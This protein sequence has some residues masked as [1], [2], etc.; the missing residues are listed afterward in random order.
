MV[1]GSDALNHIG[2]M[3]L[4]N[5]TSTTSLRV[6]YN[7][8]TDNEPTFKME[9]SNGTLTTTIAYGTYIDPSTTGTL[10]FAGTATIGTATISSVNI[11]N[12][13]ATLTGLVVN[14]TAT[15]SALTVSGTASVSTLIL[16]NPIPE[17]SV[18]GLVSDLAGKSSVGHTH[19]YVYYDGTGTVTGTTS[20]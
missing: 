1:L 7:T 3:I 13:T 17:T 16:A 5:N 6:A 4:G 2:D 8:I 12:G 9:L 19:T 14:G 10:N 15:E 18:S 20:P 11:K